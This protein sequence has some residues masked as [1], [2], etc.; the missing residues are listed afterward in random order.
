VVQAEKHL[1]GQQA[2]AYLPEIRKAEM[3]AP[4]PHFFPLP[5]QFLAYALLLIA[6]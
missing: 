1:A 5:L 2:Q 3:T 6:G 4:S